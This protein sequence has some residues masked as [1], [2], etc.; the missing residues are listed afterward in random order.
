MKKRK[1]EPGTAEYAPDQVTPA[2]QPKKK[3]TGTTKRLRDVLD[4]ARKHLR[5]RGITQP[6][7]DDPDSC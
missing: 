2:P 5:Q 6:W 7:E 1:P 4:E 3:K